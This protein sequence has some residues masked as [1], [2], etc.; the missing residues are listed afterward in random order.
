[1]GM[2]SIPCNSYYI[3]EIRFRCLLIVALFDDV[4]Q[5][6]DLWVLIDAKE[7]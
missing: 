3:S 2:D 7:I 4:S 6:R 5:L 1:M